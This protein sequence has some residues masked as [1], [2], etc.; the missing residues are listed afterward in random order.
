MQNHIKAK[1]ATRKK[2]NRNAP[3]S[4]HIDVNQ[5]IKTKIPIPKKLKQQTD[6]QGKQ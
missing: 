5:N 1:S 3:E 6:T 4:E 2:A